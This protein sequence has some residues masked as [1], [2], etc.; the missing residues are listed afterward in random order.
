MVLVAMWIYRAH[1][2]LKFTRAEE[3]MTAPSWAVGWYFIPI[4]NLVKPFRAMRQLWTRSGT[5]A[6]TGQQA[7]VLNIWWGA[8]ILGSILSNPSALRS[9]AADTVQ[10]SLWLAMISDGLMMVAAWLL[11]KIIAAI[12]EAQESSMGYQATFG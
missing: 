1:A 11:A 8:W 12:T 5:P 7:S 2:N 4:A 3:P 9:N 10:I 6:I